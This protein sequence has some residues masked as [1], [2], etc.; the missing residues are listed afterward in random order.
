M[1]IEEAGLLAWDEKDVDHA[2]IASLHK[3][4]NA[5]E[6]EKASGCV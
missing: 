2:P 3:M 4:K 6:N 1:Y 5:D